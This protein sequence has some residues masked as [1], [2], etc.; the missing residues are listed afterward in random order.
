MAL[1]DRQ[2]GWQGS[3]GWKVAFLGSSRPIWRRPSGRLRL[4]D[5]MPDQ[6]RVDLLAKRI[7]DVRS[8]SR[9]I[10]AIAPA[11]NVANLPRQCKASTI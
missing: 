8:I 4:F 9:G 6:L 7:P 5:E 1:H 3:L 2:T 11:T 10:C